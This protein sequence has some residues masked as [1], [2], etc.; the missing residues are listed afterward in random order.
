[1]CNNMT[2]YTCLKCKSFVCNRGVK[3]SV[4]A[5][6][7]YPR[8]KSGS[9][10]ALCKHCDDKETYASV[11]FI[12]EI[13]AGETNN[14][15]IENSDSVKRNPE[16]TSFSLACASRSFQEYRK[17]WAARINQHLVVKPLSG[18]IFDPYA[19][20]LFTRIRGRIEPMSLVGHLPREISR[21]CKFFSNMGA[22]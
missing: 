11:C 13:F 20:G 5:S 1:M 14:S 3:C 2:K 8:W 16:G 4:P 22:I 9:S 10:V 15:D 6:E 12:Q 18:N 17:I 19:I 7:E 21:F